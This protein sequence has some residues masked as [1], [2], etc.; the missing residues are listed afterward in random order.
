LTPRAGG[1]YCPGGIESRLEVAMKS[2]TTLALC[3]GLLCAPPPSAGLELEL[4]A[5]QSGGFYADGSADNSPSFQNY[6]VGYGTSPG[7]PRTPERRSFFVFELPPLPDGMFIGAATL[8]LRLPFGGLVFGAGPGVPGVD[9]IEPD[10][11]EGF[12]LGLLVVPLP[13]LL[14]PA[15]T[16]PEA[17]GVFEL[18]DALPLAA[19]MIFSPGMVLPDP[20]DGGPP[21]V[22]IVLDDAGLAALHGAAGASIAFGGWMPSWSEDLRLSPSPPPLYLESSELIFGF[23]D[24]HL[25]PLLAPVL[26]LSL[27]AVPEPRALLLALAGVA[28]LGWRARRRR[29]G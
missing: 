16:P 1:A 24:V 19:P 17:L 15:L 11:E 21:L 26:T 18:I 5:L 12:A 20:G 25:M 23:T 4:V 9:D 3:A 29:S 22:P 8:T 27:V 2:I 7:L 14:S 13:V 10:A 28:L 6:F